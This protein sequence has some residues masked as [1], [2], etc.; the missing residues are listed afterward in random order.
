[1]RSFCTRVKV[2]ESRARSKRS[3]VVRPLTSCAA[4]CNLL[5]VQNII[6]SGK[7]SNVCRCVGPA[8]L[9]SALVQT[10]VSE[11]EMRRFSRRK[12]SALILQ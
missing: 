2:R 10:I 4:P 12:I 7:P 11:E 3:L 6:P 5:R 8:K 1:M 9:M